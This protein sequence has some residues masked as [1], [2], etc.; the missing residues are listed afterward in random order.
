MKK[1]LLILS[2]F[3]FV[4]T[5]AIAQITITSNDITIPTH[6]VYQSTDTLPTV[7]VGSAGASQTWNMT[8]LGQSTKDTL[9]FE[10][11]AWA[12]NT[13]YPTANLVIKQ[14]SKS[15]FVYA[16]SNSSSLSFLGNAGI[17]NI[18][19][20]PT[21]INQMDSPT[22]IS[23]TYPYTYNSSF[24]N[25]YRT[26]AK[27]YYGYN[28][29]VSGN[30]VMVDSIR[31]YSSVKKTAVVDAWGSLTTPLGTYNVI[32]SKETKITHDT[33]DAYIHAISSWYNVQKT[34]DST[35]TYTFWANGVGFPL[36]T[37][38][39][40]STGNVKSVQWLTTMP[41]LGINEYSSSLNE[42]VYPNPAQ[43]EINFV[44]DASKQK[45]I[46]LFDVTGRLIDTF[47]VTNETTTINTS[48]YANGVYYYS[49]IGKDNSILNRGKFAI[50]K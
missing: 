12:P 2:S 35:T 29:T 44:A 16:I 47:S 45:A 18:G 39:M 40:D 7:S 24:N 3:S 8:A 21:N 34:A 48:S 30:T 50:A 14:G 49:I 5:S 9:L 46:K 42:S 13:N 22:E 25:N 17:A 10:S 27:F 1:T 41:A 43:N 23:V 19:G 33:V 38:T 15:Q 26:K 6:L 37:A 32:R 36:V 4:I 20:N 31:E 11:Y 28:V